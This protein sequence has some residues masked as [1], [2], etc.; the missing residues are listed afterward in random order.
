MTR[1]D[2]IGFWVVLTAISG[3]LIENGTSSSPWLFFNPFGL[4]Y[5]L[6]LYGLHVVL[7]ALSLIHI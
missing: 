7:L 2:R 4:L 6:P 1:A 3:L 5:V